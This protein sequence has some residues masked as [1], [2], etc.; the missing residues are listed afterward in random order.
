[1]CKITT[2][3]PDILS[4]LVDA[5]NEVLTALNGSENMIKT[6][7]NKTIILLKLTNVSYNFSN[8][9]LIRVR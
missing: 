6:K 5:K 7:F 4:Y 1:M 8:V 2:T 3:A 9:S